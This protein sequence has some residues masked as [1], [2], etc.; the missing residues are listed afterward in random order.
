MA[1][2]W[3]LLRPLVGLEGVG[4]VD[5]GVGVEVMA[6]EIAIGED[7]VGAVVGVETAER[8]GMCVVVLEDAEGLDVLNIDAVGL[9]VV[10]FDVA[11]VAAVSSPS[12]ELVHRT[13]FCPTSSTMLK[14]LL[15]N[16]GGVALEVLRSD[17]SKW[18]TQAFPSSRGTRAE[19]VAETDW[20]YAGR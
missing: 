3:L 18:H 2:F 19:P 12:W 4:G 8:R 16:V 6:L 5:D 9:A 11:L 14:S 10:G 7:V 15:M 1:I 20:L 13:G 17:T